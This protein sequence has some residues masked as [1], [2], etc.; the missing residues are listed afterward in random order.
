[1]GAATAL[2]AAMIATAPSALRR[3][4]AI[5]MLPREA[6]PIQLDLRRLEPTPPPPP[7][8][9][10]P[11]KR[12]IDAGAPADA[13]VA[14]T[15]LISSAASRARDMSDAQG[16]P[17]RAAAD[18][19]DDF[20]QLG[21][22]P[23]PPSP[24]PA[25]E[26]PPPS[27]EVKPEPAVAPTP[28]PNAETPAEPKPEPAPEEPLPT[29]VEERKPEPKP[30]PAAKETGLAAPK[31]SE[32]ARVE[33]PNT[34]KPPVENPQPQVVAKNPPEKQFDLKPTEPKPESFKVA[35]A[36]P[37]APMRVPTQELRAEK[38]REGGGAEDKGATSFA[39]NKHALGD[40]MLKVRNRVEREW[41]TA[42]SLKYGGAS[43]TD[44]V[45]HCVIRPDGTI[46]S[47]SIADAGKSLTY[48]VLCRDAVQKAG[49]FGP[50]PFDVPEIYRTENLEINWKFSYM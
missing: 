30:E 32:P 29:P 33:A 20:D 25:P 13:P 2:V 45:I 49:P 6:Q 36:Q 5:A 14:D 8:K 43:R 48:A 35:Q 4:D 40:Y 28:T 34:P 47:V 17:S 24:Q 10:E 50:F 22:Q 23:A 42:L 1:M 12:L 9:R 11:D 18:Q 31:T 27:P 15:D 39:A 26:T 37:A 41:R 38:G 7:P 46:E 44:A 19:I 3:I 16:D 21:A